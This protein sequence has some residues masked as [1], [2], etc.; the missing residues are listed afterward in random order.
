MFSHNSVNVGKKV[1]FSCAHG[2]PSDTEATECEHCKVWVTLSSVHW[3][4]DLPK[5]RTGRSAFE[6]KSLCSCLSR[7]SVTTQ[8][9]LPLGQKQGVLARC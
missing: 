5:T 3:D 6:L 2:L 8:P 7:K 9:I 4:I 1:L